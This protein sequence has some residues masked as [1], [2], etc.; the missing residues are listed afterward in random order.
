MRPS[1]DEALQVALRTRRARTKKSCGNG[2]TACRGAAPP[3]QAGAASTVKY[4]SALTYVTSTMW[5]WSS[6]TDAARRAG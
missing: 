3:P 2:M 1:A 6:V 5:P 4:V